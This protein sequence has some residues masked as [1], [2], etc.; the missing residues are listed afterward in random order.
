MREII[1]VVEAMQ[2]KGW[3]VEYTNSKIPGRHSTYWSKYSCPDAMSAYSL[4]LQWITE[5]NQ[6]EQNN[7]T[8]T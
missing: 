8:C 1:G 4:T 7:G 2:G 3:A 6:K 5:L